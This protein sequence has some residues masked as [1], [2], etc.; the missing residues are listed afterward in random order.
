MEYYIVS[1]NNNRFPYVCADLL[2]C[3]CNAIINEFFKSRTQLEEAERAEEERKKEE[4]EETEKTKAQ[5][6]STMDNNEDEVV[7]EKEESPTHK[8]GSP[9]Y[10]NSKTVESNEITEGIFNPFD[11][12]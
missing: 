6:G 9:L 5:E 10:S 2:S 8:A 11:C 1:L 4:F 3:E 12:K 7:I